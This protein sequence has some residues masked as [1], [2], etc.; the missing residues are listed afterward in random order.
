MRR[1]LVLVMVVSFTAA[2]MAARPDR[3]VFDFDDTHPAPRLSA[4]CGFP[5]SVREWGTL[6][7]MVYYD[8][9]GNFVSENLI[10][11][12]GGVSATNTLNGLTVSSNSAT[13]FRYG[14]ESASAS[15]LTMHFMMPNGAQ[16]V[17]DAGRLIRD[18]ATGEFVFEAG[19][20]V[21][22]A[23]DLD[24]FCAALKGE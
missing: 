21:D 9:D 24:L 19:P 18:Y 17:V 23:D 6:I 11:H 20:H 22:S 12:S 10:L 3:F 4:A 15:G 8:R 16:L 14:S 1:I 13:L 7:D 2:P 5:I